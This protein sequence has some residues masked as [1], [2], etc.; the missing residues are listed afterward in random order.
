KKMFSIFDET[1]IFI[2]TCCHRIILSSDSDTFIR[3]KYP[4]AIIHKLLSVYSKNGGCAYDI[5]CAFSTTLQNSSLGLRARD[6]NLRMMVGVFHGH[7]HNRKCQLDWHS[8]YIEGTGHSQ[9]K[10]CEHVFSS[11][12]DLTRCYDNT[13]SRHLLSFYSPL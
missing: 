13:I 12:N 7:T 4:L 2:A 9:G 1:G 5:G 3:A 10:G 11:S 6:H 8:L